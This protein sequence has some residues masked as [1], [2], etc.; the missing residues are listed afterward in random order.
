MGTGAG[1]RAG[2]Q[3]L[4]DAADDPVVAGEPALVLV[5]PRVEERAG[6]QEQ[7]VQAAGALPLGVQHGQ[8]A[9]AGADAYH[10]R[11]GYLGPQ[12]GEG[13]QAQRPGVGAVRR[14]PLVA[15]A[16]PEQRGPQR[17]QLTGRDQAPRGTT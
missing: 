5:V 16:R 15:V 7:R 9:Q 11:R 3:H 17:R 4:V 10:R 12:P 13:R 8:R 1:W 6:L 14:V 2:A